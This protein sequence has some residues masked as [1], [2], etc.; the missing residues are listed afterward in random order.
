MMNEKK[1]NIYNLDNEFKLLSR[2]II[3][4]R[5]VNETEKAIQVISY[6]KLGNEIV[7]GTD[8]ASKAD[9]MGWIPKSICKII[10][11]NN[12]SKIL[13]VQ[14]WKGD[15]GCYSPMMEIKESDVTV[16]Y[17]TK[18]FDDE[19]KEL[20]ERKAKWQELGAIEKAIKQ[21]NGINKK[22]SMLKKFVD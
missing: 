19:I 17:F 10:T 22:I 5:I 4:M 12:G 15:I 18:F 11:L 9:K 7:Y 2:Y 8:D 3:N 6:A 14:S 13:A 21:I 20:E 1:Y 16:E